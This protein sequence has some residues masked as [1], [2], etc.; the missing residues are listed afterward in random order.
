VVVA[1]VGRGL[2]AIMVALVAVQG[3]LLLQV[4]ARLVKV[5]LAEV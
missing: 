4:Q 5:L 3:I 2:V 1:V